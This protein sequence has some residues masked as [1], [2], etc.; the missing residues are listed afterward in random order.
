MISGR[1]EKISLLNTF[2][3]VIRN[4]LKEA[5]NSSFIF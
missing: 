2:F 1:D 4:D 3:K 5:I